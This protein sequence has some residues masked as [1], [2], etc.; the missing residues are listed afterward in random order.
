MPPSF[1]KYKTLVFRRLGTK[2][3][4]IQN[5]VLKNNQVWPNVL[6]FKP[7]MTENFQSKS[8]RTLYIYFNMTTAKINTW[9]NDTNS[10]WLHNQTILLIYCDEIYQYYSFICKDFYLWLQTL[11]LFWLIN[12][13]YWDLLTLFD[14]L[15]TLANTYWH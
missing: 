10:F 12:G 4:K 8:A 5:L 11:S 3:F 6:F 15:L 2:F 14:L 1:S 7:N 13:A 9:Y